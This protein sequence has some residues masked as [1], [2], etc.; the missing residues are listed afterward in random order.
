[1]AWTIGLALLTATLLLGGR[2]PVGRL[3]VVVAVVAVTL[4]VAL[5]ARGNR[6]RFCGAEWLFLLATQLVTLQLVPLPAGLLARVRPEFERLLPSLATHADGLRT[7]QL[8]SVAPQHTREALAMWL[9]YGALFFAVHHW[10]VYSRAAG[11]LLRIVGWS[12]LVLAAVGLAQYFFDN[13]RFLW[14]YDNPSRPSGGAVMGPF[15]NRNHFAH[16]MALGIGP[17][18]YLALGNPPFAQKWERGT[19]AAGLALV[20]LASLLSYSRGGIAV[21]ALSAVL[22]GLLMPRPAGRK[23]MG[24][25]PAALISAALIIAW[26]GVALAINGGGRVVERLGTLSSG[27]LES[28]SSQRWM[29][30]QAMGRA[31]EASPLVGYGAASHSEVYP[32]FLEQGTENRYTHG[33]SGYLPLQLENGLL[34]SLLLLLLV[35]LGI[36][37]LRRGWRS[38]G[39]AERRI[40]AAI[41]GPLAAS[42]AHSTMDF[43][44]YIPACLATTLVLLACASS[45]SRLSAEGE[46][47]SSESPA[48][49]CPAG[50][51]NF[52]SLG[53]VGLGFAV[54]GWCFITLLPA[55][56]A[57]FYWDAYRR[58]VRT[59][60]DSEVAADKLAHAHW[61]LQQAAVRNPADG[62]VHTRLAQLSVAMAEA[63]S[64][65]GAPISSLALLQE[66][67]LQGRHEQA[68]EIWRTLPLEARQRLLEADA[69][70]ARAIAETPL[71]GSAYVTAAEIAFLG[72]DRLPA[73]DVLLEH[74]RRLRPH[75]GSIA[76]RSGVVQARAGD[77]Q[78][79]I[80]SWRYGF[81]ADRSERHA[82][83]KLLSDRL[84][85]G[86]L[87]TLLQPDPEGLRDIRW[88]FEST[89]NT[90]ALRALAPDLTEGIAR[91]ARARQEIDRQREGLLEASRFAG[92]YG[93]PARAIELAEE[94]IRIAPG[95]YEAHRLLVDL[96]RQQNRMAEAEAEVQ[97]CLRRR[98]DPQLEAIQTE[99]VRL[100]LASR[101]PE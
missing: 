18:I 75:S 65:S 59:E 32:S 81:Q 93:L 63:S 101:R 3:G 91:V 70:V 45:L 61:L 6:W 100:R 77:V 10:L 23:W 34:G 57:A 41:A 79:C 78:A 24:G 31:I 84:P 87:V 56:K 72:H 29:L 2:H 36:G 37:W 33:E 90:T 35:V 40:L 97:W 76:L 28:I 7:W 44:W 13:G 11:H 25:I 67:W 15:Q 17:L 52:S 55:A 48:E 5:A 9:A 8:I 20:G 1:M 99:L 14:L 53:R 49:E 95:H 30:W 26:I 60:S 74:A 71:Q 22:S 19:A 73:A 69:H 4:V 83:L 21:V 68:A 98:R 88:H 50:V 92:Q 80:A 51:W 58:I 47:R 46:R 94:A 64:G 27:S 54:L 96:Y 62:V 12:T 82:T 16:M 38:G 42:L 39:V 89:G 86:L 43:V 85:A 66:A